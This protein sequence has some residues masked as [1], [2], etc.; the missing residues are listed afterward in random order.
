MFYLEPREIYAKEKPY[1]I[2]FPVD[3]IPG[4][5]Q[6]N[7]ESSEHKD[8]SVADVREI[9]F[10]HTL[11][12]SG[13][14]LVKYESA[15]PYEAFSDFQTIN[16][17]YFNE[18]EQFVRKRTGAS[19]V[20]TIDCDIRRRAPEYPKIQFGDTDCQPLQSVH[21]DYT[22]AWG[23]EKAEDLKKRRG[24]VRK[25]RVQELTLW[26]PLCG[27]VRDWPLAIC[28]YRSVDQ[29]TDAMPVDQVYP[30]LLAEGINYYYNSQHRW[31]FA[32]D[33][34]P[35]EAWLLK[36]IDTDARLKGLAENCPH[37]AFDWHDAPIDRS[38]RESI[39]VRVVAFTA[40]ED[41]RGNGHSV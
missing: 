1:F 25:G 41:R 34:S 11:D 7:L 14:E 17:K 32:S 18:V 4:A 22:L 10:R 3:H 16:H 36:I 29:T 6:T 31:Y 37:T 2:F 13:F 15:I 35:D 24:E 39:E 9:D 20:Q 21:V 12:T 33:M 26:R 19:W 23:V 30:H 5:V 40:D 28:D 27:P 8:V 38:P